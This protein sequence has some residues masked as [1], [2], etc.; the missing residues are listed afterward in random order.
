MTELRQAGKSISRFLDAQEGLTKDSSV[1]IYDIGVRLIWGLDTD[2]I[3]RTD[4][5]ITYYRRYYHDLKGP[6]LWRE[7]IL[8]QS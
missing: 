5:M 8:A 3:S 7:K 6:D 1:T 4:T 2:Q